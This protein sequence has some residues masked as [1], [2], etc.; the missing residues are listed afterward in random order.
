MALSN[1]KCNHLM[2]LHVKGLMCKQ[3][4]CYMHLGKLFTIFGRC[5]VGLIIAT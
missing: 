1:V 4:S 5:N 3:R 2:P